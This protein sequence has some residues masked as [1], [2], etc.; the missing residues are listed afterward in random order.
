MFQETI[1][2]DED[3]KKETTNKNAAKDRPRRHSVPSIIVGVASRLSSVRFGDGGD[4]VRAKATAAGGTEPRTTPQS[5]WDR[6]YV[7]EHHRSQPSSRPSRPSA[8]QS[9]RSVL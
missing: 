7:R 6:R 8:W 1:K 5:W 3:K 2:S 9:L 4:G